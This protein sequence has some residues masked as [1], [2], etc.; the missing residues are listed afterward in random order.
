MALAS[1]H[2]SLNSSDTITGGLTSTATNAVTVNLTG[3]GT[4]LIAS[5]QTTGTVTV[6]APTE[7]PYLDASTVSETISSV[8]EFEPR[9]LAPCRPTLEHSPAE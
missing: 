8:S 9:R 5:G 3:G 2:S 7:D 4:I 6:A 1:N